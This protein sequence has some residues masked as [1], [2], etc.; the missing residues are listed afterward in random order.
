MSASMDER[1]LIF[2]VDEDGAC[3]TRLTGELQRYARDYRVV[4]G[5]STE[6]AL[7]QLERL[8]AE[9][10]HVALV[11]AARG[12]AELKGEDLL[13]RVHELHPHAKRGLLIE[14]GGWNDPDTA[15][16]I[17]TAMTCGHIDYYVLKPW[18]EPDELF[19][20]TVSEFLFEW[21]R[22]SSIGRR[23]ITVV[24]DP[25]SPSGY[26]LRNL[27]ARNGVPH[28]FHSCDSD[29][30]KRVLAFCE[31]ADSPHPVVLLPDDTVLDN[32]TP[33][34]LAR[35]GYQMPTELTA[36]GRF[37]VAIVGAGPAGLASAVYASSEGLRALVVEQTSIG[38]QST[39]SARI[40][41]YLG[42]SRGVTGGELAQRAYQQAWVFG[43][44]F[45][46]LREIEG[47]RRDGDGFVLTLDRGGE[48][49]AR[50]VV[51]AM[52]V[53]YRSLGIPGLEDLVGSGVFYGASRSD[54]QLYTGGD[55]YVVGGANSAGQAAVLLSGYAR[56]VTLV[57]RGPA[58]SAT[59]SQYLQD[60]LASIDNVRV[61]LGT[62]V[63][64]VEGDAHLEQVALRGPDGDRTLLADALFLLIGAQPKTDWLPDKILDD[65]GFVETGAG[66]HLFETA[67]P[68][69][70]AV[71]DVRAGSVKRVAS[72]VG[73]GSVVIQQV[74]AY[75]DPQ[76]APSPGMPPE[77]PRVSSTT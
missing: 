70:F 52:G 67:L 28:V 46:L 51:L 9:G 54:A 43:T 60:E 29:E 63:V 20:R 47:L 6:A 13:A 66:E 35:E 76:H 27:L 41:N 14:W 21:R 65:R 40:R 37:D 26:E 39:S 75:L 25:R 23:E 45:L 2:A 58:L 12:T 59:M 34:V 18:S 48:I 55:V 16:C 1:P 4:C 71:G 42:F 64:G 69:V 53:E 74:H 10:E 30:G 31:K 68:G 15:D 22:A 49:E 77:T 17:R 56:T 7:S 24:A 61:E 73:E 50:S 11:L 44:E 62:Q 8:R 57:V 38:G 32:P 5:P 72:A 3:I 36:T 33:E 19:H